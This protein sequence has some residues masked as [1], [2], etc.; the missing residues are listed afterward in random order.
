V[1]DFLTRLL[2]TFAAA[3]CAM[4]PLADYYRTQL[5]RDQVPGSDE[6]IFEIAGQH[7]QAISSRSYLPQAMSSA[8]IQGPMKWPLSWYVLPLN[9]CWSI[10]HGSLT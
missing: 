3:Q 2:N 9:I 4:K 8:L 7:L 1:A 5:M 10:T 6:T